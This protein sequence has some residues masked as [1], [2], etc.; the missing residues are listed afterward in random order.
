MLLSAKL[1]DYSLRENINGSKH[2][3]KVFGLIYEYRLKINRDCKAEGR[4]FDLRNLGKW[5]E[6]RAVGR[7]WAWLKHIIN[8]D[9]NTMATSSLLHN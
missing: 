3:Y 9:T 2:K 6:R 5:G 1:M 7:K 8:T 4:L